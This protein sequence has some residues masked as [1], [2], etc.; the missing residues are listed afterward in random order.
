MMKKLKDVLARLFPRRPGEAGSSVAG[1]APLEPAGP[2]PPSGRDEILRQFETWLQVTLAAEPAPQGFDPDLLSGGQAGSGG[3]DL[4]SLWSAMTTL[5]QEVKI[6]G[7]TFK[8]LQETIQPVGTLG[9]TLDAVAGTQQEVVAAVKNLLDDER[10]LRAQREQERVQAAQ[11]QARREF[12][13][14]LLDLRDRLL[15]GQ[16]T[17]C[18]HLMRV[19]MPHHGG[20]WGRLFHRSP[21]ALADLTESVKALAKGYELTLARLEEFM[22]PQ[23]IEEIECMGA[24]FDPRRMKAVDLQETSMVP[25]GTVV[26]VYRRGYQQGDRVLR[27]AEV[28]VARNRGTDGKGKSNE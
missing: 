12:V 26:E 24:I 22:Q 16:A 8:Q 1:P 13:D 2:R 5:S 9:Q 17:A 19:A 14:G 11:E 21:A 28:K 6:Q 18:E 15:R 10:E 27:P 4:Y 7:R 20:R 25:D 3:P 23:G